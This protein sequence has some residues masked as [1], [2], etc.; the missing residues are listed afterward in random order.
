[1]EYIAIEEHSPQDS[2][3]ISLEIGDVI[4]FKA[5]LWNGSFDGVNRR[6]A[7]RGL[8]PSYKVEEKWRIVD[9]PVLEKIFR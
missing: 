6:T 2:N 1:H 8:L 7:K 5:N 4:E 3:E 9:F